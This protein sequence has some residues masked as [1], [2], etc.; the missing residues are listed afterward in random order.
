MRKTLRFLPHILSIVLAVG[1]VSCSKDG[2]AGPAGATGPAGPA[3]PS[4]SQG[5]AGDPGT[6]NV[7]YSDW[8]DTTTWNPI[9]DTTTSDTVG[10][11][12]DFDVAALDTNILNRGEIKVYVNLSSD[13][14]FPVI[15]PLPFNNGSVFID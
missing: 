9:I 8:I 11:F 10:Y 12:A 6:A 2:P 15:S 5:P 13:P 14:T 4:G 7:M 1:I 3:G